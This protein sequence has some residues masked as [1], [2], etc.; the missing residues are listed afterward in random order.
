M[1]MKK[2]KIYYIIGA[3]LAAIHAVLVGW[4]VYCIFSGVESD[5]PMYWVIFLII[6]FPFSLIYVGLEITFFKMYPSNVIINIPNLVSFPLNDL[7]NFV[8]PFLFLGVGGTLWWFFLPVLIVKL[9]NII[10]RFLR[11]RWRKI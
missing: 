5:W 1:N 11:R 2:I 8:L 7:H 4:I 6:D 3:I 9:F 10:A